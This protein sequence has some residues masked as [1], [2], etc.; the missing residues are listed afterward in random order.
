MDPHEIAASFLAKLQ[1]LLL[2]QPDKTSLSS[3][4][5]LSMLN[6]LCQMFGQDSTSGTQ[7]REDEAHEN[8]QGT[9]DTFSESHFAILE[10]INGLRPGLLT[11]DHAIEDLSLAYIDAAQH[12]TSGPALGKLRHLGVRYCDN[13]YASRWRDCFFCGEL[14]SN[15]H[16]QVI[17]CRNCYLNVLTLEGSD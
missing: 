12:C 11:S 9:I 8:S 15:A 3:C 1:G 10:C 14:G 16:Q 13:C 5:V 2:T 6:A 7:A 17:L 4:E